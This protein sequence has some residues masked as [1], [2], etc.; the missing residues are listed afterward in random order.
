MVAY[1]IYKNL[2]QYF[3]YCAQIKFVSYIL[4]THR[5]F[6]NNHLFFIS[7]SAFLNLLDNFDI[8]IICTGG[9]CNEY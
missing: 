5:H 8:I 4:S 3:F 6:N 9:E 2:I 7:I 1:N